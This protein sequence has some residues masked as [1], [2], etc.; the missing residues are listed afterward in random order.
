[1]RRVPQIALAVAGLLAVLLLVDEAAAA[2]FQGRNVDGR[3]YQASVLNQDF[4]LIDAVEVRFQSE[5]AFVYL[6]GGGRLVLVLQGWSRAGAGCSLGSFARVG[7][8]RAD[9]RGVMTRIR[10]IALATAGLLAALLTV[11]Q[12]AAATFQ[13]RNVDGR[14]YQASILN[15]DYGMIDGVEVRFESERAYIYLHGG[16]RLVLI[17]QDEDIADPRRIPADDL[18]RGIVWEINVKDLRAR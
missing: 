6:H 1:M 5:H 3:R 11:G 7:V 4:G 10:P 8:S 12:A 9:G 14:R 16:G 17:L 18:R 13:G 15:H 2:T